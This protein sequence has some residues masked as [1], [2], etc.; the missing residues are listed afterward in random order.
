PRT[1]QPPAAAWRSFSVRTD[2]ASWTFITVMGTMTAGTGPTSPT[3]PL[4]SPAGRASLCVTAACASTLA[5]A[6]TATRTAT[7]NPTSGIARPPSVRRTSS[8]AARGAASDSRGAVTARTTARIT[9]MRA[10]V[11]KP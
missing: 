2:A 11:R 9:A 10:P 8:A 6:V 1:S 5:G 7:I 3:V 4:T